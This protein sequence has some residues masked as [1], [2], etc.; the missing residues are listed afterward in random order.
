[1]KKSEFFFKKLMSK[2]KTWA[3][4]KENIVGM[5]IEPQTKSKKFYYSN[6][7]KI[8]AGFLCPLWATVQ[9]LMGHRI[10]VYKIKLGSLTK[11]SCLVVDPFTSINLICIGV[12]QGS[13]SGDIHVTSFTFT[14]YF[15]YTE[16]DSSFILL[17][18][19]KYSS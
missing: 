16:E 7:P 6:F 5:K 3:L 11:Q 14:R 19:Q 18:L 8:I 15:Q 4:T 12:C 13:T 2:G 1:M 17:L 9:R 10:Y